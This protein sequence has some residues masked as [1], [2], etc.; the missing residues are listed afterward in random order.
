MKFETGKSFAYL[1]THIALVFPDSL[2]P[3][4]V[5]DEIPFEVELLIA[6]LARVG[7]VLG[8]DKTE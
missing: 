7:R 6:L 5:S 2:V 1:G 8:K 4:H 3:Q